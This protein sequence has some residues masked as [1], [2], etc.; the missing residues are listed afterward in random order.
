[1]Y[2]V[3]WSEVAVV[4][5]AKQN[6]LSPARGSCSILKH[7]VQNGKNLKEDTI[8]EFHMYAGHGLPAD[9]AF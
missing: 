9:K 3:V 6:T 4:V 1:M 5:L 8:N 7:L 2:D